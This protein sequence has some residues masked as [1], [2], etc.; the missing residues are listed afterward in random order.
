ML[1]DEILLTGT[2]AKESRRKEPF[3]NNNFKMVT[4]LKVKEMIAENKKACALVSYDLMFR[5]DKSFSSEVAEIWKVK[6]ERL[7]H[8]QS[9]LTPQRSK[10]PFIPVSKNEEFKEQLSGY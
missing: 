4:G 6:D 1:S 10:N 2:I 5:K 3:V 7:I 8:W 9:I